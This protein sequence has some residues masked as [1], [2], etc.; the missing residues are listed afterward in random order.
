MGNS[1]LMME[2]LQLMV[3]G[4]SVVFLFLGLLIIAMQGTS[5]A[6]RALEARRAA[7][8]TSPAATPPSE[9]DNALVAAISIAIQRY[10]RTH[11]H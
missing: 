3:L 10:R 11:K 6:V 9:I 8:S 7:A 2:G 4:M 5:R 1:D